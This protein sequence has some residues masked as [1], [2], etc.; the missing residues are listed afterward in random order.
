MTVIL[1][2]IALT[3]VSASNAVSVGRDEN[4]TRAAAAAVLSETAE[5]LRT[6]TRIVERSAT[7]IT[8]EVPDRD[9]DGAPDTIQYDWPAHLQSSLPLRRRVN[10]APWRALPIS[11][12]AVES[13]TLT[14]PQPSRSVRASV[15]LADH[16][17]L[18][19]GS[20]S[21]IRVGP[22]GH[23]AQYILPSFNQPVHRWRPERVRLVASRTVF[24]AGK[25]MLI[26]VVRAAP[27]YG[28]GSEVVGAATISELEV[29]LVRGWVT[30]NLQSTAWVPAGEGVV[31]CIWSVDTSVLSINLVGGGSLLNLAEP[32]DTVSSDGAISLEFESGGARHAGLSMLRSANGRANA[33][34]VEPEGTD[35]M[36]QLSGS[37]EEVT[38]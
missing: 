4:A 2:A 37:V 31:V 23:I 29:G 18:N 32:T 36:I 3:I 30:A 21:T 28:P 1:G 7:G 17:S 27:G 13:S 10:D 20:A 9:G 14:I 12:V 15:A 5:E 34:A 8:L 33:W 26:T 35:L 6:A 11:G 19:G 25:A 24:G 22:D 38:P 16:S